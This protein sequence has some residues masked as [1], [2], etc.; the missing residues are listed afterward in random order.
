MSNQSK[1]MQTDEEKRLN[2]LHSYNILDSK[3]E[4]S[5][6]R[7]TK[8]ASAFYQSPMALVSFIDT[9]RQWFKSK[10]GVDV[11]ETDR[12][13]AFCNH[14]IKQ[15]QPFIIT[16]ATRDTRFKDNPLVLGDPKIKFYAGVPLST[17]EGYNLG[18]LC[19][20]D[21]KTRDDFKPTSAEYLRLLADIVMSE[22]ELRM[23]NAEFKS[24]MRELE[25]ANRA[26]Q[27]FYSMISHEIRTP[28]STV[29]GLTETMKETLLDPSQRE[30][31]ESISYSSVILNG[32]LN[33][34]LDF[35]K[36]NEG[37]IQIDL[38]P[39]AIQKVF[40]SFYKSWEKMANE[41]GLEFHFSIEDSIPEFLLLDQ[42]RVSQIIHN[43]LSNAIKFTEV[44]TVELRVKY[45]PENET[46]GDMIVEIEDT[47]RGM[48]AEE[49][50][51]VFE[52][53]EQANNSITR[54][55]GGTGL[56]MAISL[57]LTKLMHGQLVCK[58]A[59]GKG[60]CFTLSIH[61]TI[62]ENPAQNNIEAPH[63]PLANK[64]ILIVD[65][66]QLNRT[67]AGFIID[68]MG[69][70]VTEADNGPQAIEK[71]N[72]NNFDLILLDV[73]MPGMSGLD[74]ANI[75]HQDQPNLPIILLSAD[76]K[77]DIPENLK[78]GII[79]CLQKPLEEDMLLSLICF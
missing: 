1:S 23:K 27:D 78:E 49:L 43:I 46:Q 45:V 51:R 77:P 3:S 11:N 14:A 40:E 52:P 41:K 70:K 31:L 39:C 29:I 72:E 10:V 35:A 75:L 69:G 36:I 17:P 54:N 30:I 79:G 65:D 62:P 34:I 6:D 33:D 42:L 13:I 5:F 66:L 67:L 20:L 32:L 56:G 21:Q 24:M 16:D 53:F 44:G 4:A 71:A 19:I 64:Q 61:T 55:H 59:L 2:A 12:D 9:D 37:K 7:I 60:T 73:H 28:L 38:H 74:V 58:S 57:N 50:S 25:Q 26:K 22:M 48:D 15:N 18:T 63:L 68:K 47:G 76:S 8:L